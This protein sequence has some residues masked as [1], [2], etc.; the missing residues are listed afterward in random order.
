VKPKHVMNFPFGLDAAIGHQSADGA[1]P[2]GGVVNPFTSFQGI[3]T[4]N[5]RS[6]RRGPETA[7]AQ[8]RGE[9]SKINRSK[10][11]KGKDYFTWDIRT[12]FDSV[13]GEVMHMI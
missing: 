6:A 7:G 9:G 4:G 5:A 1:P 3:C 8:Q 12:E 13:T 2:A 10:E 11:C